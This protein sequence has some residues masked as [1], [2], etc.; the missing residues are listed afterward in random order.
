MAFDEFRAVMNAAQAEMTRLSAFN[1]QGASELQDLRTI[2]LRCT[3]HVLR[4][5]SQLLSGRVMCLSRL[6]LKN[7][8]VLGCQF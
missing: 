2:Q 8:V 6:L 4:I 3:L 7:T 5:K 1:Q